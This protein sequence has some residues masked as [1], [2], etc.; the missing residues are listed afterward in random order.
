[1]WAI[2]DF[3]GFFP[4]REINGLFLI[5]RDITAPISLWWPSVKACGVE[6]ALRTPRFSP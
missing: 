6:Y 1:M 2:Q 3:S 5:A 4:D